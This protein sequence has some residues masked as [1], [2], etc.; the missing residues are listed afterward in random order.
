[1]TSDRS[2]AYSHLPPE[3][4]QACWA[5]LR[6]DFQAMIDCGDVGSTIGE[7]LRLHAAILFGAWSKVRV[8]ASSRATFAAETPP[9]L[10]PEV[11]TLLEEGPRC[12][13]RKT[14]ATCREILKIEPSLWTFAA[15]EGVEPTNNDAERAL[16]H[17]V[18]WRKAS[19]GTDSATGSRFTERIPTT[20]ASCRRQGRD[21]LHS[22]V[23]AVSAHRSGDTPP[24]LIPT[25]V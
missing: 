7:E 8:G 14:A 18:C 16:R 5:Y 25:G 9:W 21:L 11:R 6:R 13:S 12:G 20:V 1:V 22:L 4:R 19:F 2:S 10:R 17:A 3:K 15:T 23:Q 24:S